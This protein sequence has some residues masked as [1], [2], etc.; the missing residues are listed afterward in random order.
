[1][2]TFKIDNKEVK[3]QKGETILQVASREGIRIPTLCNHPLLE[4][5]GMCRL[6]TV[7]LFDGR[8]TKLVTACNYPVWEG[9][10]VKTNTDEV[11]QG[12][13]LILELLMA[14]CPGSKALIDIAAEYEVKS[15]RFI[16]G[17]SQ[18]ILCGMCVRVCKEKSVSALNLSGRSDAIL[19]NTPFE[20]L[21]SVCV[22]CGAC[23]AVC[24]AEIITIVEDNDHREML[25]EGKS[26]ARIELTKCETCGRGF[27]PQPM[28][29]QM[30]SRMK[31]DYVSL[32]LDHCAECTRKQLANEMVKSWD[33]W[34]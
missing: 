17:D 11:R 15:E 5:A 2:F 31:E 16:T 30:K 33:V 3:A 28:F 18:C 32:Y 19:V 1:M 20:E 21:S 8:R 7:E 23:E 34:I 10:E 22:G 27:V 26:F 12:R 9:M 24:P 14:R 4:P 13:K 6:C 29:K 25:L